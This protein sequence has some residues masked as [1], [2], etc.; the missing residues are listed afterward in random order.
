MEVILMQESLT[1]ENVPV[2]RHSVKKDGNHTGFSLVF[3]AVMQ[4]ILTIFW[5]LGEAFGRVAVQLQDVT[6]EAEMQTRF[7]ALFKEAIGDIVTNSG[8]GMIA[9]TCIALFLL[10]LKL[11]KDECRTRIMH[12]EKPMT[13]KAFLGILCVFMG[14][15]LVFNGVY[16]VLEAGLN[17]IGLTAEAAMET[18]SGGHDSLSMLIYVGIVAPVIEELVYRGFALRL[19]ERHGKMAAIIAS[20]I[21]FGV[22]HA[23]LPQSMFACGIGLVL[24]Y[25]AVEYSIRWSILLHMINNL[26]FSELL[27]KALS[28]LNEST[29]EIISNSIFGVFLLIGIVVLIINRKAI[30]TFIRENM[31]EKP[32]LRWI[33]TSAGMLLFIIGGFVLGLL[34]LQPLAQ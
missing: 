6:D 13:L 2:T 25:V 10:F 20:S 28:G 1:M 18:A 16:A 31:W 33:L 8:T 12:S 17:C 11:R 26:V 5:T 7:A 3:Y 23:N 14:A 21:L 27:T 15:Q 9:A 34:M 22:M 4:F 32:R 24:G 30:G 19:L 29:Q